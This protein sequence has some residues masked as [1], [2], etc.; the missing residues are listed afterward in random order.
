MNV[1]LKPEVFLLGIMD[2]DIERKH[3]VVFIY[4]NGSK[5]FKSNWQN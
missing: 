1:K 3:G 4:D 2:K 5:T